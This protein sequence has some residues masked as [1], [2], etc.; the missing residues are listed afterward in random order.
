V[1][2]SDL[3]GQPNPRVN[4]QFLSSKFGIKTA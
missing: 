3:C 2:E 4:A 1:V